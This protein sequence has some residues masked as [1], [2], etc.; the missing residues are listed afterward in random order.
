MI[1]FI[2]SEQWKTYRLRPQ[3]EQ[4]Q[5]RLQVK[6]EER[7]LQTAQAAVEAFLDQEDRLPVPSID[8]PTKGWLPEQELL[9]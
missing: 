2:P 1:W 8:Q 6:L 9:V 4:E 3:P 5:H 7:L